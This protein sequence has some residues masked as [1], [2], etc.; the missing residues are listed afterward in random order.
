MPNKDI[1]AVQ[2][3]ECPHCQGGVYVT[4]E[5]II[6]GITGTAAKHEVEGVKLRMIKQLK[7]GT[8]PKVM[9]NDQKKELIDWLSNPDNVILPKDEQEFIENL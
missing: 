5:L 4:S 3:I 7:E 2:L 9:M 1:K 8:F 6:R